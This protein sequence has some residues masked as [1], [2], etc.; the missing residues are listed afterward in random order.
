MEK[1]IETIWKDGFL[2]SD[3]LLAPKLNNLYSQKSIDIV[4]KFR[5]MYKINRIAIVAFAFIILPI[6]FLVKI[7]YMG[8]G[9]FVLFFVIVTIA[10]KFSKRLDTLDKTQN[11]YQY[12]ISFDN[13]VKEMTATN[14]KLSRFLYPYVF[15]IMVAGFWFGSIGGDIPGNKFVNF[16]LLKFPGTYLVF[17]FPLILIIGG[18]T[19]ISLLAYFGGQIGDFDLKLGYGRIL[20]KLDGILADMNELRN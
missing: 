11:S 18:G 13:W 6:S 9:M 1:S 12:L 2:K 17:G 14:T 19:I 20:K 8:I 3:A 7:P 5:R 16:I 4:D 10:Q 15:I